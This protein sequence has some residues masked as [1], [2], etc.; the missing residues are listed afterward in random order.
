MVVELSQKYNALFDP[1]Q[2]Q[3]GTFPTRGGATLLIAKPPLADGQYASG[4]IRYLIQKRLDCD[5]GPQREERQR[6]FS[7]RE[8]LLEG[9]DPKRFQ[10]NFN[11]LHGGI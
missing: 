7:L 4:E 8:G 6:R 3:L 11:L 9:N 5:H 10:I 2:P 1:K